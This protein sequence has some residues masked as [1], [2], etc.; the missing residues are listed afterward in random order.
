MTDFNEKLTGLKTILHKAQAYCAYQDRCSS[1]VVQKLR[2]WGVDQLRIPKILESLTE[3]KFLDDRRYAESFV[4]SKFRLKHWGRNK[5][6]YELRL[7][8]IP[9]DL[10]SQAVES[11]DENEYSATLQTLIAKKTKEVKDSDAFRKKQKIARFLISKGFESELV[12]GM[13]VGKK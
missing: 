5:I 6:V 2:D 3:D 4:S 10:I 9:S 11:I 8:K 13:M 12:F 7:K 1:E